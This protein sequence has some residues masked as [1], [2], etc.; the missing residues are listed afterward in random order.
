MKLWSQFARL[1]AAVA[2]LSPAVADADDDP[3]QTEMPTLDA[4]NQPVAAA[5]IGT[6]NADPDANLIADM[7]IYP[8]FHVA[9]MPATTQLPPPPQERATGSPRAHPRAAK[10]HGKALPHDRSWHGGGQRYGG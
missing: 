2:A 10:P 7:E 3:E 1:G 5:T 6:E 8:R 9:A 4:D